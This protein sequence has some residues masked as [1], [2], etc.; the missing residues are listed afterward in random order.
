MRH[1]RTHH[2]VRYR[3]DAAWPDPVWGR[4]E[5]RAYP[6]D[7]FAEVLALLADKLP[8]EFD[9]RMDDR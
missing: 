3:T 6:E 5:P 1:G 2:I 4:V 8:A 9:W 7:R